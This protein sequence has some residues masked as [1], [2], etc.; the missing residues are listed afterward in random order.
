MQ[1]Y[2]FDILFIRLKKNKSGTTSVYVVTTERVIGRKYPQPRVIKSFGAADT[3]EEIRKLKSMAQTFL[4]EDNDLQQLLI[5][6]ENDI[7]SCLCEISGFKNIYGKIFSSV[8]NSLKLSKSSQ[9]MLNDLTL[10]RIIE[11]VSKLRTSNICKD[12]GMNLNVDSIYKLMDKLDINHIKELVYK[13]TQQLLTSNQQKIDVLFYDL[14]TI[15]FETNTQDDYRDFGFSKDGKHQHVQITLAIIATQEG[16][17]I[18]YEIF[19]GNT[20]EG[21]TLTP[22]LTSLRKKYSIERVVVVADSGL[23]S[24]KNVDEIKSVGLEYVIGARIKNLNKT[25]LNQVFDEHDYQQLNEDMQTK[26]INLKGDF[27]KLLIC[28]SAKRAKKDAI[29]RKEA[30]TKIQQHLGSSLKTKLTGKLRKP[31]VKLSNDSVIE[32]DHDK[33]ADSAK[34]DGYFAIQTNIQSQDPQMIIQQYKRLWQIEQTFRIAKHNLQIRPVFHYALKRIDAHFAICYMALSL[35]R[36]VE[37]ITHRKNCYIPLEQL[38]T[39]LRQVKTISLTVKSETFC[40]ST[41]W[42]KELIPIYYNL[43][44]APPKRFFIKM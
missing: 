29:D 33:I 7:T 44:V 23:I 15:A 16:L 11:P 8:F 5:S 17:P 1:D 30:I 41:N 2:W 10:M 13:N 19:K 12:Y 26:F 18:S 4:Q 36:S 6:K 9:Q 22:I 39:L 21:H 3:E 20:F 38:H 24:K 31:Y 32:I 14:T 25:I 40:I 42:P 27:D 37:Y 28:H 34:F 35:I 43:G